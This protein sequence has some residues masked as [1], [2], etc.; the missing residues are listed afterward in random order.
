MI[1]HGNVAW[2]DNNLSVSFINHETQRT[3]NEYAQ[4][5]CNISIVCSIFNKIET[6]YGKMISY[7][8]KGMNFES[9]QYY[10]KG[11][12][13]FFRIKNCLLEN[14]DPELCEGLRT[15]SLA[16]VIWCEKIKNE[17]NCLYRT[18]VKY[19]EYY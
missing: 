16:E 5:K 15:A 7:N 2:F 19:F 11:T 9:A 14:T 13:I 6:Y 4:Q 1:A 12:N 17:N 18:G 8:Q 10:T 3:M